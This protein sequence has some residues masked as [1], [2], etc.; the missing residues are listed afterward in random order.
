MV[1]DE[2]IE[3]APRRDAPRGGPRMG[4]AMPDCDWVRYKP[5]RGRALPSEFR[6]G[7]TTFRQVKVL[8]FDFY[9]ATGL[10]RPE[11]GGPWDD[12]LY[13]VYHT[14]RLGPL[15]LG[16]LGRWLC[17][18]E[19]TYLE[20]LV[21]VDGVPRL[22]GREGEA[23]M[24]REFVAGCNLREYPREPGVSRAFFEKLTA[25]LDAVHAR[26]I[27]HNDLSKPENV[28][29]REDGGPCLIDFQIAVMMT[30]AGWPVLDRL[31][32]PILEYLQS[33]DRYHL[34]KNW[35][36]RRLQDF[37][38]EDLAK[39]RAKGWLVTLHGWLRRPYR[40]LRAFVL[41]RFLLA[42][43]DATAPRPHVRGWAKTRDT[44]HRTSD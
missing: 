43:A 36:R 17:D 15:P 33:V 5:L 6:R 29:V 12:V 4:T 44:T 32:R 41:N 39:A 18:R 30:F 27:A 23:G 7:D 20:R 37:S 42:R 40:A 14:D 19:A 34:R 10:Y 31:E 11:G 25:I 26:G 22:I 3:F 2:P 38:A 24:V 21:G 16:W 8:K 35:R 28:L 13:K 9:A 1:D